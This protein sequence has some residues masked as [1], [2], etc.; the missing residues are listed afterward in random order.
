M[1]SAIASAGR[2]A[3]KVAVEAVQANDV[4][5]KKLHKTENSLREMIERDAIP[6]FTKPYPL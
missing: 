6:F 4:T 3:G 2:D 5:V 1:W